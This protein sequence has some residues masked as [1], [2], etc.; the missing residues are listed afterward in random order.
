[1]SQKD[2]EGLS[3]FVQVKT[4]YIFALYSPIPMFPIAAMPEEDNSILGDSVY[5]HLRYEQREPN[6][7]P[8]DLKM[9]EQH[10]QFQHR[11]EEIFHQ[12]QPDLESLNQSEYGDWSKQDR[13][14]REDREDIYQSISRGKISLRLGEVRVLNT[15]MIAGV[16][17]KPVLK[18]IGSRHM[19]VLNNQQTLSRGSTSKI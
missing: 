3:C 11:Q 16:G 1:M 17:Y 12:H 5:Q 7:H 10:Q 2:G 8:V 15:M 9:F 14:D 19:L 18:K 13:E 4:I 6:N